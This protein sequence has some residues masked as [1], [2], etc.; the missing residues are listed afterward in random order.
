M[1]RTDPEFEWV[2]QPGDASIRYLHHGF[3]SPL[4]RWHYHDEYELHLITC[5]HGKVFVGDYIGNFGPNSLVLVGPKLPHN[6]ISQMRRGEQ[7]E[8][9]DR[10]IN[11]SHELVEKGE[12]A[13]PEMQRL[14][15]F[16]VRARHGIEFL[17]EAVVREAARLMEEVAGTQGFRRLTRFWMLMDLL[18]DCQ[19]YRLL[20]S[21]GYM[22]V[23]DEKTLSRLSRVM[24]YIFSHYDR[25]L[26]LEEVA[27]QVDMTTTYFSRFFRKAT[28]QRFIQF[29]NGLRISRACEL[30][31]QTDLPITEVCFQVGFNNIANFN[32]R[33]QAIRGMTP[34]DYRKAAQALS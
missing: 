13:F 33:F 18:A 3:P 1:T 7:V 24:D 20:A 15:P 17:D 31:S 28:G 29:V 12:A 30:L 5:T 21:S 10:V 4:V 19:Q 25:E 34:S 23:T 2:D 11:F 9:R 22:P 16:W 26:P 6:W 14:R 8:L 32:R 27:A